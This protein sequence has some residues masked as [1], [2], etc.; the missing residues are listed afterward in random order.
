MSQNMVPFSVI[1]TL[2]GRSEIGE[3][4]EQLL[5]TSGIT[6]MRPVLLKVA[7]ILPS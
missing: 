4:G 6:S 1:L 7:P 3:K 2:S 5:A